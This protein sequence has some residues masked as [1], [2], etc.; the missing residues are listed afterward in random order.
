MHLQLA[1]HLHEY[2][3]L[4]L[5]VASA[6]VVALMELLA[7]LTGLHMQHSLRLLQLPLILEGKVQHG[8]LLQEGQVKIC[9]VLVVV[10]V[11]EE[12]D[13]G[14]VQRLTP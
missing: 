2:Q 3:V 9:L 13:Y 7:K 4:G 5:M 11:V 1:D 8:Q 6:V 14:E 12:V 10:L